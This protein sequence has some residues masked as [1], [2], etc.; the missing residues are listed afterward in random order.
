MFEQHCDKKGLL[1]AQERLASL[2]N[3]LEIVDVDDFAS[4]KVIVDLGAMIA[5][6]EDGF[7]VIIDPYPEDD[8][9]LD[10]MLIFY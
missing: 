4:L 3:T 2:L 5:S 7:S 1:F 6:Y 9:I 10:P 8:L